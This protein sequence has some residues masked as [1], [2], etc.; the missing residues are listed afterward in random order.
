MLDRRNH[1]DK[2][3]DNP[4]L[5]LDSDDCRCLILAEYVEFKLFCDI[6]DTTSRRGRR[7]AKSQLIDETFVGYKFMNYYDKSVNDY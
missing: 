5:V 2:L 4:C 7:M 6:A 1:R 3:L